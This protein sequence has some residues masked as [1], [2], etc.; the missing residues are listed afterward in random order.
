MTIEYVVGLDHGNG[1]VKA[2]GEKRQL[3]LPSYI[4]ELSKVGQSYSDVED[5]KLNE[6]VSAE[7]K[8]E[9]YVWGEDVKKVDETTSTYSQNNRYQNKFYQLVSLFAIY[10]ALGTGKKFDNILVITGV[11]SDEKGTEAE[12]Q[13]IESLIGT[14][15]ING[16]KIEIVEVIVLPQP[17]GTVM[18]LY[19]DNEGYIKDEKFQTGRIGI[20]DV[21][22]GTTDLDIVQSLRRQDDYKSIPY[23]MMDVYTNIEKYLKTKSVSNIFIPK[24]EEGW[25]LGV[26]KAS[27]RHV[28]SFGEHKQKAIEDVF[29]H[30]RQ[31]IDLSWKDL[32]KF[33]KLILTGGGASTFNRHFNQYIDDVYDVPKNPQTANVEGFFNYG[34]YVQAEKNGE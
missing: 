11:P 2:K 8:K 28:T 21:G 6:Y 9:T 7:Y 10:E 1:W 13:L 15:T 16:T 4:A 34:K 25:S 22:T 5:L 19:L 29:K 18:S 33:D 24:V 20:I 14:H 3:V 32:K 17:L 31:G 26:Y 27:E 30:I 23:G 12:A